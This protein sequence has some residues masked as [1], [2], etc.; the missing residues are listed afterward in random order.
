MVKATRKQWPYWSIDYAPTQKFSFLRGTFPAHI[1]CGNNTLSELLFLIINL[2]PKTITNM[3]IRGK[4]HQ[5]GPKK[6]HAA[7]V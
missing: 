2:Q 7:D 3:F 4:K 6:V 1:S 5:N